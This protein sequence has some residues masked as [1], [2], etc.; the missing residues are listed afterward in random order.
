[1]KA[2]FSINYVDYV[3][4]A[5]ALEEVLTAVQQSGE[6]YEEKHDHANDTTTHHIYERSFQPINLRLIS[7]AQYQMYKMAGKP[8]RQ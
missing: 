3:V 2:I 1:M 5:D 4:D 6:V 8:K 7:N